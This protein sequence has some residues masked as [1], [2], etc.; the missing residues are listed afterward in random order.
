MLAHVQL[1]LGRKCACANPEL[2]V[3]STGSALAHEPPPSKGDQAA[4]EA[5]AAAAP[6]AC[7]DAKGLAPPLAAPGLGAAGVPQGIQSDRA[8]AGARDAPAEEETSEEETSEEG[9]TSEEN[10]RRRRQKRRRQKRTRGGDVRREPEE[11]EG[12]RQTGDFKIQKR[13]FS[14][15]GVRVTN[16]MKIYD[17]T[18]KNR[19][20]A[21]KKEKKWNNKLIL[22]NREYRKYMECRSTLESVARKEQA[23]QEVYK[24]AQAMFSETQNS[25][26]RSA[27]CAMN[28]AKRSAACAMNRKHIKMMEM[29]ILE[30]KKRTAYLMC[31]SG[32]AMRQD[33]GLVSPR[34]QEAG[35]IE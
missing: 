14:W 34:E 5:P 10:Q 6:K 19:L 26:K 8:A 12:N 33:T 27:A 2:R 35:V 3:N 7:L 18:I 25:A 24:E 32:D 23:V 30:M 16:Q 4:D 1:Q 11:P 21:L 29:C 22:Y 17:P 13:K 31:D 9:E 15:P 20:E 28:R